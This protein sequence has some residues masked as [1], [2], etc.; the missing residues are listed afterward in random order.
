MYSGLHVMIQIPRIL[1]FFNL[2]ESKVPV[3]AETPS[4]GLHIFHILVAKKVWLLKYDVRN[5]QW[6]ATPR[7]LS[8]M[9]KYPPTHPELVS[10]VSALSLLLSALGLHILAHSL[11]VMDMMV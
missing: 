9:M 1:F 7:T 2:G 4:F 5:G 11:R 3:F 6:N 8:S 10:F